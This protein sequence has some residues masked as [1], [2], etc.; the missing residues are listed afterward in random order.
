MTL[1][2]AGTKLKTLTHKKL[3]LV[4]EVYDIDV[5]EDQLLLACGP[6]GIMNF[7]LCY[8]ALVL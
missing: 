8:D 6:D 4:N 2:F 3:Q 7:E 5:L 1:T